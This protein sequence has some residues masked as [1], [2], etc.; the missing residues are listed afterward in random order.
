MAHLN[1]RVVVFHSLTGALLATAVAAEDMAVDLKKFDCGV[2]RKNGESLE[3]DRRTTAG[4]VTTRFFCT[5][6]SCLN[7]EQIEAADGS[8]SEVFRHI[9]LPRDRNE[10]VSTWAMYKAGEDAPSV[11]RSKVYPFVNCVDPE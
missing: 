4:P 8:T 11:H 3:L 10:Y 9:Y 2:V 5:G 1:L 6:R 7:R